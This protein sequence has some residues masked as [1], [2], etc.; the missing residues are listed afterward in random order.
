MDRELIS[1]R[2][3]PLSSRPVHYTFWEDFLMLD[4]YSNFGLHLFDSMS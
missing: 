4:R 3:L 2:A 1:P